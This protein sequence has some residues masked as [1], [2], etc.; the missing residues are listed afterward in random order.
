MKTFLYIRV[1]VSRCIKNFSEQLCCLHLGPAGLHELDVARRG[2][3]V[4]HRVDGR[5]AR[6]GLALDVVGLVRHL[7]NTRQSHLTHQAYAEQSHNEARTGTARDASLAPQRQER[8]RRHPGA[9]AR[10]SASARAPYLLDDLDNVHT[11]PGD[12]PVQ[13]L[14]HDDGQTAQRGGADF[15]RK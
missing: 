3:L 8:P 1:S 10:R 12:Q 2:R 6:R 4:Q 14:P 11:L 15:S 9:V 5:P 13:E 7:R